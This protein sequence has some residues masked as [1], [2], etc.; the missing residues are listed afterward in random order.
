MLNLLRSISFCYFLLVAP[1]AMAAS[2]RPN[3]LLI[4][5]D[6][7]GFADLGCYGAQLSR[8]HPFRF[9]RWAEEKELIESNGN[10]RC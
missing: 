5:A 4:M 2:E 9:R 3:I 10:F 8:G 6:D 1:L 7:L